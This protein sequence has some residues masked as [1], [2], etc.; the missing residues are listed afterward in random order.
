MS[1]IN[2]KKIA[3]NTFSIF[4]NETELHVKNGQW[5]VMLDR[6]D[7]EDHGFK[8]DAILQDDEL[9]RKHWPRYPGDKGDD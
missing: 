3:D 2:I 4:G 6:E 8:C 9:T 7:L 1:K 5:A